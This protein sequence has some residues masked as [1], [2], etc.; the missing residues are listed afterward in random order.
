M[1]EEV[2]G[3]GCRRCAQL[4]LITCIPVFVKRIVSNTITMYSSVLHVLTSAFAYTSVYNATHFSVLGRSNEAVDCLPRALV[5]GYGGVHSARI[6]V[7]LAV[8]QMY[9]VIVHL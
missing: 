5:D 1:W 7:F 6:F 8:L 3:R 4:Q 2:V 9:N